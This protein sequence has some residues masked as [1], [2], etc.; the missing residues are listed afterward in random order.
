MSGPEAA[1]YSPPETPPPASA[2]PRA[3]SGPFERIARRRSR[4]PLGPS[5]EDGPG[6]APPEEAET[7]RR[8]RPVPPAEAQPPEPAS[9][10]GPTPTPDP[11]PA[12]AAPAPGGTPTPEAQ[13]PE[14]ASAAGSPVPPSAAEQQPAAPP[15]RRRLPSLRPAAPAALL[16]QGRARRRARY[17]RARRDAQLRDLGGL[18]FELQRR[19]RRRE[20]LVAAKVAELTATEDELRQ[21]E[22]ALGQRDAELEL[23]APVLGGAC[24]HCGALHGGADRFCAR[25]GRALTQR[26]RT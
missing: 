1:L 22:S 5:A 15:R 26:S 10:A 6:A 12:D 9:A 4:D 8:L 2:S 19:G 3:M 14:A 20:D 17:L 18:A 21:I 25:C 16:A 23:S 7:R 11:P 13:P 24:P